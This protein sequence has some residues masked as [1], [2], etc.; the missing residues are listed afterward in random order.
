MTLF[1]AAGRLPALMAVGAAGLLLAGCFGGAL[2]DLDGATPGG[3]AFSQALF[4]N[5]SFLARSFGDLQDIDDPNSWLPF[6]DTIENPLRPIQDAFANKGLLA[7][8][9]GE[10]APEPAIDGPSQAGRA[11]LLVLIQQAKE[12]FPDDSARAQAQFDCWILNSFVSSQAAASQACHRAFDNALLKLNND[13]RPA[14]AARPVSSIP[15]AP[16]P[17]IASAAP[18]NDYTVYFGFDSWSLSPEALG[19]ITDAVNMA[20]TGGQSRISIVGHADTSGS[21]EYNQ[22]LSV[23]RANVVE[24]TMVQMGARR[25]AIVISGVGEKDLAVATGDGVR[26]A[27]NRR[28]VVNLL[29]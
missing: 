8:D 7:A 20:R 22:G 9:G 19:T 17:P 16:P 23:R 12:Q 2:D 24:E 4:Q 25:D 27:K 21:A 15:V 1:K 18:V 29:P 3:S 14:S 10:P 13:L 28:A 6:G 11:R 26:E 5:Y